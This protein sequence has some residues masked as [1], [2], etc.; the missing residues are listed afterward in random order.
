[1][2]IR[3]LR[4]HPVRT[5]LESKFGIKEIRFILVSIS[6]RDF[7]NEAK[8][9]PSR[10]LAETLTPLRTALN[11]RLTRTDMSIAIAYQELGGERTSRFQSRCDFRELILYTRPGDFILG[12]QLSRKTIEAIQASIP[13]AECDPARLDQLSQESVEWKRLANGCRLKEILDE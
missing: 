7:E 6:S 13:N 8:T 2:V 9:T 5:Q 12:W 10:G 1:E 11:V 4:H 3:S